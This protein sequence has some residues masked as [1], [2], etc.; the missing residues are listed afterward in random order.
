TLLGWIDAGC[1]EGDKKDAPIAKKFS[2]GWTI[3]T[4]DVVLSFK[5]AITVPAKSVK[6]VMPYKY[7]LLPTNF[8][9]DKW[10]QAV[11]ARP[12]NH[13][14]VHHIIVYVAKGTARIKTAGDG[15]GSGLLVA[16]APGDLGSVF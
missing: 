2:E 8:D 12:G 5:D 1:P 10:I 3:G 9:E 4:P 7:V 15:I 16:Y 14:V 11:E 6:G 13:A